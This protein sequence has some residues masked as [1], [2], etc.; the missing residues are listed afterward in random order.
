MILYKNKNSVTKLKNQN[1]GFIQDGHENIFSFSHN[2]HNFSHFNFILLILFYYSIRTA[3]YQK[4]RTFHSAVVLYE[5]LDF[6]LKNTIF[7]IKLFHHFEF[8]RKKFFH[9]SFIF[10]QKR[11]K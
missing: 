11:T 10:T 9:K 7:H 8:S 4:M 2:K 1:G 5:N 6:F 3:T